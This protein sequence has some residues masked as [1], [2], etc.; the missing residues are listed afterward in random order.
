[1]KALKL[2]EQLKQLVD[3]GK[4]TKDTEAI[5]VG[6]YNLGL[7]ICHCA[8]NKMAHLDEETIVTPPDN[9]LCLNVDSYLCE[10]ED[11]GCTDLWVDED[12]YGS[13][14]RDCEVNNEN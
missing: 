14:E 3:D 9:V 1:M 12:D 10:C 11:I 4:I 6:E 2:Y 13:F 8:I 5:A 7:D